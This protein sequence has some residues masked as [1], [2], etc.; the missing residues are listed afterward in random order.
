MAKKSIKIKPAIPAFDLTMDP[1]QPE[2]MRDTIERARKEIH[3]R[4]DEM[5][6]INVGYTSAGMLRDMRACHANGVGAHED[7]KACEDA[8][9]ALEAGGFD[10]HDAHLNDARLKS[11][12]VKGNAAKQR[13]YADAAEATPDDDSDH[14][15]DNSDDD[16]NEVEEEIEE[17]Y[18]PGLENEDDDSD[19]D[20]EIKSAG[21]AGA[22]AIAS[23]T[24]PEIEVI[25]RRI[26]KPE[27]VTTAKKTCHD[28]I[29]N[30]DGKKVSVTKRYVDTSKPIMSCHI[31]VRGADD[32]NNEDAVQRA[33]EEE[34]KLKHLVDNNISFNFEDEDEADN[35]KDPD[36]DDDAAVQSDIERLTRT[37]VDTARHTLDDDNE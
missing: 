24:T 21:A 30:A 20:V 16:S 19:E 8:R 32:N 10:W 36:G 27:S 23:S 15:D 22:G 4:I 29:V 14:E 34:I 7:S 2:A 26:V 31:I 3:A 28:T 9:A 18:S 5:L 13:A 17:D 25:A 1:T 6:V 11:S 37:G 12:V 35:F 33:R